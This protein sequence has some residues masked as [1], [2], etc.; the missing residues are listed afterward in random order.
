MIVSFW[1]DVPF[2]E[3]VNLFDTSHIA[4]MVSVFAIVALF[5]WKLGFVKQN[6]RQFRLVFG[7]IT[8]IQLIALYSWSGI[9]LGFSLEAGLPIHL[10]RMASFI[11]LYFL[12]T[13][14]R[15][16]F[17]ALFYMSVFAIVAI[18]YPV[19]VHPIYTH[20]IGWSY[21]ISHLMI[22]LVW[23]LIVFVY[24]YRPNK[25]T[26]HTV[27]FWFLAIVLLVWRFNYLVGDGEY[28]YL[29]GDVNRPFLR[30]VHD[31]IWIGVV[32][33]ISYVVMLIM[34]LPFIVRDDEY[35]S[36]TDHS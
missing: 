31:L 26:M 18:F 14:D 35:V 5:V 29:R 23:I 36:G 7:I 10:C 28:L 30:D 20:I 27:W 34:T 2:D 32:M 21:Q 22:I 12:I 6:L 16:V 8:S 4:Y 13:E 33:L 11:G 1:Y 17:P 19:N 25:Q 24:G 9:E 15:S 3:R